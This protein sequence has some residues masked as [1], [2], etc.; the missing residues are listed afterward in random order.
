MQKLGE[1]QS[2]LVFS[3]KA[4]I[5]FLIRSH[6]GRYDYRIVRQGK[7]RAKLCALGALNAVRRP[8]PAVRFEVLGLRRMPVAGSEDSQ[9]LL[10]KFMDIAVEHRDDLITIRDGE[11]PAGTKVI[12]H[13]DDDQSVVSLHR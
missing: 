4:R 1:A 12:L 9:L 5:T 8:K 3:V 13:I 11:R 2:F 10:F 7:I 6:A